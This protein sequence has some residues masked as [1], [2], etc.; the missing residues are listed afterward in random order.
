MDNF[1]PDAY[2]IPKSES[3]YMKFEEG[4]NTFRALS[5]AIVGYEYWNTDN[6][7][8]RSREFPDVLRDIKKDGSVKPFWA[9]VVWNYDTKKVNIL[10][11]TQKGIMSYINSLVKNPKW[12]SPKGYDIVVTRQGKG[13]DTEYV[14]TA[15][16]HSD[17]SEA[18]AE[19]LETTP[20]N[21]E[22]L[23]EGEDPFA[24]EAKMNKP[25]FMN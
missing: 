12:G 7:P 10:E 1:L 19:A 21:L 3:R 25:K 8:V 2:E 13:M 5:S 15:E 14:S 4:A 16:P 20:V 18:I 11:I 22:A 24:I 6:K 9:F 17:L 23:Y